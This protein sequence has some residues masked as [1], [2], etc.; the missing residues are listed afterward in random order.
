MRGHFG[1]NGR[2]DWSDKSQGRHNNPKKQSYVT[3]KALTLWAIYLK[4]ILT[5]RGY[6][7]IS[8]ICFEPTA[9]QRPWPGVCEHSQDDY[10]RSPLFSKL[11]EKPDVHIRLGMRINWRKYFLLSIRSP[12]H[13]ME[14]PIIPTKIAS[15]LSSKRSSKNVSI[16]FVLC[17]NIFQIDDNWF[18]YFSI[19][20][21]EV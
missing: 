10:Y 1:Q 13:S 9:K 21:P 8:E 15:K 4:K 5:R 12:F 6:S 11:L 16:A 17:M 2:I 19:A 14:V 3:N 18:W 20:I 7:A